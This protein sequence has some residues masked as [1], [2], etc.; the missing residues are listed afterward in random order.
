MT[1]LRILLPAAALMLIGAA[2]GDSFEPGAWEKRVDFISAT[3]NGVAVPD[4]STPPP[5]I[6][7]RCISPAIAADPGRLIYPR[8]RP[9]CRTSSR[10]MADGRVAFTGECD[11]E[12]GGKIAISA[13]GGYDRIGY[14]LDT[15]TEIP[16]DGGPVFMTARITAR[17]LGVCTKDDIPVEKDL[18][19]PPP[20]G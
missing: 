17:R 8:E 14:T 12:N 7:R 10:S 9:D 18:E 16:A 2:A 19:A 15:V 1:A 11:G 3:Q 5:E 6:K 4:F 13:D 20:A